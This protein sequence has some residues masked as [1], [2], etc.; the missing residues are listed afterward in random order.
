M[1]DPVSAA[2][3]AR[4]HRLLKS[5]RQSGFCGG[6]G[7]CRR[8]PAGVFVRDAQGQSRRRMP[9]WAGPRPP[10]TRYS[11]GG[12]GRGGI[13]PDPAACHG[14][15][16]RYDPKW[17]ILQP[18]APRRAAPGQTRAG[19]AH[20]PGEKDDPGSGWGPAGS[21]L[22]PEGGDPIDARCQP[23]RRTAAALRI[24]YPPTRDCGSGCC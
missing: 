11:P 3:P 18:A 16:G 17:R 14:A 24:P 4:W 15:R 19:S 1:P 6:T 13:R 20:M 10:R 8:P 23:R 7:R 9:D 21:P 12:A 22:W 2:K 5:R